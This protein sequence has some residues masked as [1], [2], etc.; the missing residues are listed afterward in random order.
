MEGILHIVEKVFVSK[1]TLLII[2]FC[3]NTL[4][5]ILLT[6]VVPIIPEVMMSSDRNE[7]SVTAR[8]YS[9]KTD[10]LSHHRNASLSFTKQLLQESYKAL[11]ENSQAGLLLSSKALIQIAAN[12]CVGYLSERYGYIILL[13]VGTFLLFISSVVYACA[14]TFS[15]FLAGRLAHGIASSFSSIAGMSIL[16]DLYESDYERSKVM[17]VAMGGVALGVVVGY[18]FGGFLYSFC[19]QSSPFI[20]LCIMIIVDFG[21]QGCIISKAYWMQ[22]SRKTTTSIVELMKDPLILTTSGIIMLTTMAMSTLEPTIPIWI[23]YTMKAQNWQLGLVFLPDSIGYLIGT[24]AFGVVARKVGRWICSM[25]CMILVGFCLICIPFSTSV[26]QL[27]LPHFGIGLG[28]GIV[29]AALMPLLALLV[30]LRH[31][32]SYGSVYAIAQLAVCLAYGLGPML[33]GE[34]VKL[35]GFPC[36]MWSLGCLLVV[37][38]PCCLVLRFVKAKEECISLMLD[39]EDELLTKSSSLKYTKLYTDISV[40]GS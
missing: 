36:L 20:I 40:D 19:G 18:P 9:I 15:S 1:T 12:P 2:I 25:F 30:D 16:A 29:D 14:G 22:V 8:N 21:V 10:T 38:S 24:N 31:V 5:N 35:L 27:I 26:S 3:T 6:S 17:G 23:L 13:A 37:T 33:G 28:L 11:D 39:T 34:I 4:D 32:T 7:K